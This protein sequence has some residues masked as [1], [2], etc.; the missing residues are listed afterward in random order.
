MAWFE[1]QGARVVG[2]D[3]SAGMLAVASGLVRGDLA[4]MDMRALA[5][6]AGSF[7]VV[8]CIAALLHLPKGEAPVALAEMHRVLKP[9]GV[10]ALAL[11]AGRGEVWEPAPY[12]NHPQEARFFARYSAEEAEAM[13]QR[14][15]FSIFECGFDEGRYRQWLRFLSVPGPF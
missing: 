1:G 15:G 5:F 11:Q 4:R 14:A 12:T 6:P 8:W 10:M 9:G 13:L 7:D 2:V 3:R